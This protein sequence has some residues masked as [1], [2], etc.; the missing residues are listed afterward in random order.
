MRQV[1]QSKLTPAQILLWT[2]LK[3]LGFRDIE[4]EYKPFSGRR[5]RID[6]Y[7]ESI[8]TGWEVDGGM[9]S[10]GHRHGKAVEIDNEKLNL[11]CLNGIYLMRFTNHQVLSGYA[12]EFLERHLS[13]AKQVP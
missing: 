13:R 11:C 12:K 2:H 4:P 10:G 1:K 9:W 8:R 3:E 6:L 5:F 7:S